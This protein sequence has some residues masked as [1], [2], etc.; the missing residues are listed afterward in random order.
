MQSTS[1]MDL[2][3]VEAIALAYARFRQNQFTSNNLA[4]Y[5]GAIFSTGFKVSHLRHVDDLLVQAFDCGLV[6]KTTQPKGLPEF[7]L[8]QLGMEIIEE[9]ELPQDRLE[10]REKLD[11]VKQSPAERNAA[12]VIIKVNQLVDSR[13]YRALKFIKGV[14]TQWVEKGWVSP[15]QVEALV[16]IAGKYGEYVDGRG[17]AGVAEESWRA[18]Y[19]ELARQQKA[20]DRKRKL[21]FEA[22]QGRQYHDAMKQIARLKRCLMKWMP[23]ASWPTWRTS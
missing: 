19:I 20:A 17:L 7:R 8:T 6:S 10:K 11:A 9:V 18:Q 4:L 21:D 13:D 3:A 1:L 23:Q 12:P 22:E 14:W 5:L 16:T 2:T 15:A